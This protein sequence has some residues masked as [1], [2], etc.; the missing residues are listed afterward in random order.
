MENIHLIGTE[1]VSRAANRMQSAADT[2]RSAASSI[3]ESI[4]FNLSR[5][6]DRL[7]EIFDRHVSRLEALV[8]RDEAVV[9]RLESG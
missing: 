7:D 8:R 2:M 1:E 4:D 5:Q 3:H 9:E 6:I